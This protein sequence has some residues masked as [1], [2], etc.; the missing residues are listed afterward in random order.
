MEVYESE[1]QKKLKNEREK[2]ASRSPA[3]RAS[4]KKTAMEKFAARSKRPLNFYESKIAA[5][6][7]AI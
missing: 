3:E 5:K 7:N 4:E 2:N 1:L 6:K